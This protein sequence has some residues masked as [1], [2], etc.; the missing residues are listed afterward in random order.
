MSA[1][2][3]PCQPKL[4]K[5]VHEMVSAK[6]KIID[7]NASQETNTTAT[8]TTP[9][10]NK[11][12]P[13][14]A[15]STSF[16]ITDQKEFEAKVKQ[17]S[18]PVIVDFFAKWCDPCKLMAPCLEAI[19]E[20]MNGKVQLAKVDVDLMTDLAMDYQVSSVP[21]LIRM[22]DGREQ[23]RFV[24]FQKSNLEELEAFVANAEKPAETSEGVPSQTTN[25]NAPA[26]P[27]NK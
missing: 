13:A 9:A 1:P 2:K 22:K 12:P 16:Q 18:T 6:N 7:I 5:S 15:P 19:V 25:E 3:S 23:D 11:T 20:R 24:G 10:G 14:E 17:A 8:N 26:Q 4:T 21:V 27:G